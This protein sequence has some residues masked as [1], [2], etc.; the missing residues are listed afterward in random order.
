MKTF[1]ICI[2]CINGY[3]TYDFVDSL[4]NQKDFKSYLIGIDMSDR[5]KGKILCNKFYKVNDPKNEKKYIN[6]LI[7]IYKREK[8]DI[9]FPLSDLESFIILKNIKK[10]EKL[11]VKFKLPSNN[12]ETA[13]IL[14]DKAKF[15]KFCESNNIN[16][17]KFKIVSNYESLFN[18]IKK[19]LKKKFI[20]KPVKGSGT[21]NV[22]LLNNNSNKKINILESRN[23][24][25]L[26]FKMLKKMN[27]F[28]K[29]TKFILMPFYNGKMYDVD[30]IA[31]KG[32]IKEF[33]IRERECQ[34]RFIF[35][36][37]GH[38]II[39][40]SK[41]KKLIQKF[42]S[43]LKFSGICDFDLIKQNKNYFLLEASCRFSGSVGIC[44]KSGLNFPAQMVRYLMQLKPYNYQLNYNDSYRPF[45]IQKKIDRSKRGILLNDYIPHFSKQLKY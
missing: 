18:E 38:R 12:F 11:S 32:K 19:N 35:Y 34:N 8:F 21:K 23:C 33:S 16:V 10:L 14:Y 7:K 2:S 31:H 42:V 39:K 15:L 25:E 44:T 43:K 20:L 41:I 5:N 6:D 24:L 4:K 45:L 30:C 26:N 29:K 28:E 13:K 17:G 3:L 1:K 9:F 27:I 37:V 22:F 40:N 36:S